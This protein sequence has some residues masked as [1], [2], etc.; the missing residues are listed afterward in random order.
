[1]RHIF[2]FKDIICS[3]VANRLYSSVFRCC[4]CF[5]SVSLYS[6]AI[7][8]TVLLLPRIPYQIIFSSKWNE[9][10]TLYF[11]SFHSFLLSHFFFRLLFPISIYVMYNIIIYI[12]KS[13]QYSNELILLLLFRFTL[14]LCFLR[15]VFCAKQYIR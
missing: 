10:F 11:V 13:L 6:F 12:L 4:C 1:M 3:C 5:H 15:L 14:S 8:S 7:L 2:H 9:F